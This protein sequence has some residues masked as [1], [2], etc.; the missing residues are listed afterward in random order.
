MTPWAG[1]LCPPRLLQAGR[2]APKRTDRQTGALLRASS[3]CHHVV[4]R[5]SVVSFL[6]R[7]MRT[8]RFLRREG[9]GSCRAPS[10]LCGAVVTLPWRDTCSFPRPLP[11]LD[12]RCWR[13]GPA[14][15]RGAAWP[16]RV[17][18]EARGPGRC[19]TA[20]SPRH[21]VRPEEVRSRW[22]HAGGDTWVERHV[23]NERSLLVK[24]CGVRNK[25]F[26]FR[27]GGQHAPCSRTP[28]IRSCPPFSGDF[29]GWASTKTCSQRRDS[30]LLRGHFTV[31]FVFRWQNQVESTMYNYNPK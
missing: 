6:L 14:R 3:L 30:S 12:D 25:T 8:R 5:V 29:G 28:V 20:L 22:S 7:G 27:Q 19:R 4:T 13:T 9:A 24:C 11:N 26:I 15:A 16:P 10:P 31:R 17:C 18:G 23:S 21:T 1:A 2:A